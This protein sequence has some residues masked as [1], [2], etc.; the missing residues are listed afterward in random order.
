MAIGSILAGLFYAVM[1]GAVGFFVHRVLWF[2]QYRRLQEKLVTRAL[3]RLTEEA[4]TTVV[5]WDQ[6]AGASWS[7]A[8]GERSSPA[9][10]V[11][12]L[13]DKLAALEHDLVSS[14][15]SVRDRFV[16]HIDGEAEAETVTLLRIP[17]LRAESHSVELTLD[18][19]GVDDPEVPDA[20]IFELELRS[21]YGFMRRLAAFFLGAADVVYSSQHVTR[22]AQNPKV[23]TG[24]LLR[25]FSLV[26]VIVFALA[27]DI[28]FGIR[29]RL[30]TWCEEW[31]PQT[32]DIESET[33]RE[34][35]PPA[36][37]MGIWLAAYGG[38]Y[39]GLYVFL[40]WR[41][42]RHLAQLEALKASFADRVHAVRDEHLQALRRWARDYATSLDDATM[43]TMHQAQMLVQRTT[44]RL[45][46]RIASPRL[47]ELASEVSACFFARLPE[48]ANTLDDVATQKK[49][50]VAHHVWP[51]RDEMSYQVE[52]AQYRHAW[53]DIEM[54]L[55]TL[56]GQHPDPELA[57]QLWRSLVRYARM[58]PAIVPEDLFTKLQEAHGA[59]VSG[60]IDETNVDVEDLD[61]RLGELAEA[62]AHTVESAGPL[63]ESRI[64]LTTRSM[65]AA[66]AE[67]VAEALRVRE[68]ARLEAMAFEI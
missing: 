37:A 4:D 63:V 39:V 28:G 53:R 61:E 57:G 49:H 44:H 10:Y 56:R 64:D 17:R 6:G 23:P 58:F 8:I 21:R 45:R 18:F 47:L 34:Y 67:L 43:L 3:E 32:F 30:V 14:L 36:V 7:E 42:G 19:A 60:I 33:L 68:S 22:M 16:D 46:R 55:S 25:R 9:G 52:L 66:I 13:E 29:A 5:R 20:S 41:S 48:S 54:C 59:V 26:F 50:S 38:V 62:L 65:H 51:R 31:L 1:L 15:T 2:L 12:Q 27:I 11:R 40:R 35:L 24:V